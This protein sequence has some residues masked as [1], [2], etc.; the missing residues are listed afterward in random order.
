[1]IPV[2]A[3]PHFFKEHVIPETLR[4]QSAEPWIE[5]HILFFNPWAF[6]LSDIPQQLVSRIIISA[7]ISM[8]SRSKSLRL[9]SLPFVDIE[10][11]YDV[12]LWIECWMANMRQILHL[13]ILTCTW[14]TGLWDVGD[15]IAAH[16]SNDSIVP[17]TFSKALKR[18]MPSSHLDIVKGTCRAEF[19]VHPFPVTV[20]HSC[21][22]SLLPQL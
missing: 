9:R 22:N 4:Q 14:V 2:L 10:Y 15:I 8:L 1:M 11:Q 12:P 6:N 13:T 7:P 20:K 3:R 5:D 17:D 16:G 18:L 19:N 21:M